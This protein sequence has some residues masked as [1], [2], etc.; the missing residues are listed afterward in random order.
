[1]K[2]L[3]LTVVTAVCILAAQA[4]SAATE[5][6]NYY[7]HGRNCTSITPGQTALYTQH[8]VESGTTNAIDVVCPIVLNSPNASA[9][10]TAAWMMM[11]GYNRS[12]V[13]AISCTVAGTSRWDGTNQASARLFLP[14]DRSNPSP[15][16]FTAV[17]FAPTEAFLSIICHLPGYT[18]VGRSH[19]TAIWLQAG[20]G[21]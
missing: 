5:W 3:V 12:G 1:M 4:A 8:G 21:R 15:A 16:Q 20:F 14:Y 18:A 13:N 9:E 6:Q 19:L 17:N 10:L 11:S 7:I 2:K